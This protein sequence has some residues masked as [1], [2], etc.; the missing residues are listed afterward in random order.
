MAK[1][2]ERTANVYEGIF[3]VI[4]LL[5]TAVVGI[6]LLARRLD[7]NRYAR[8]PLA[9][10]SPQEQQARAQHRGDDLVD[11]AVGALTGVG[12]LREA[13]WKSGLNRKHVR[14]WLRFRFVEVMRVE[15]R[16]CSPRGSSYMMIKAKRALL[17]RRTEG[18]KVHG[19]HVP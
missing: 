3:S 2:I 15:V 12:L 11:P 8:V 6:I 19:G 16:P 4:P 18:S 5:F 14:V 7:H 9:A 13:L 10:Q 17:W 1:N